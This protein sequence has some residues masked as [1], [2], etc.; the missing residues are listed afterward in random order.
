[1][2]TTTLPL[3]DGSELRDLRDRGGQLFG[4]DSQTHRTAT[5]LEDAAGGGRLVDS[6]GTEI[7]RVSAAAPAAARPTGGSKRASKRTKADGQD[8]GRWQTFNQFIDSIA[9]RLSLAERVVWLLMFRHARDGA[10]DTTVR[11]LAQGATISRSTAETALAKLERYGLVW[12]IWKSRDKSKA[13]RFGL[14]PTPSS[15]LPK[16]IALKAGEPSR[17]SGRLADESASDTAT[18]R[19]DDRDA[20]ENEPSRLTPGTVPIIGTSTES[21]RDGDRPSGNRRLSKASKTPA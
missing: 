4:I 1:M 17:L 16:L 21:R 7:R 14:H 15:C 2:T 8:R 12:T 6:A 11:L 19:P 20:C 18:N 10:C 3:P 13:S 9:P 5:Y